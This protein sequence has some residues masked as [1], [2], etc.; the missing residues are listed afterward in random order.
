M[1]EL[2]EIT[3][4]ARALAHV[5]DNPIEKYCLAT[6]KTVAVNPKFTTDQEA[7]F[8]ST[9]SELYQ[10]DHPVAHS[11]DVNLSDLAEKTLDPHC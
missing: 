1:H 7:Q 3:F 8:M 4:L 9:L 2:L 5:V 11:S 10:Q 6:L